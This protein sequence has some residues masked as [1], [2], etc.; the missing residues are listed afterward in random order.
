MTL[1][2][3]LFSLAVSLL[4]LPPGHVGCWVSWSPHYQ[5]ESARILQSHDA[6]FLKVPLVWRNFQSKTQSASGNTPETFSSKFSFVGLACLEFL[7]SWCGT[8]IWKW[9]KEA[10]IPPP[11][12]S[13]AP[14]FW[15]SYAL[16][17]AWDW[18]VLIVI[19]KRKGHININ[20]L[21][22]SGSG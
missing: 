7:R 8:I 3:A 10:P 4:S 20:F 22:W 19:G 12:R 16:C 21:I 11:P 15:L 6:E 18:F 5:M 2:C 9:P 17:P 13:S 1:A 14:L